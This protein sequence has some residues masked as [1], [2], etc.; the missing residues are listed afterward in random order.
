MHRRM[1]CAAGDRM[2][3]CT[4]HPAVWHGSKVMPI[5]F[6]LERQNLNSQAGAGART[7]MNS[8]G[9]YF[10]KALKNPVGL[11]AL[12]GLAMITIVSGNFIPVLVGLI[13]EGMFVTGAPMLPAWRRR[14]DAR[15]AALAVEVA[16]DKTRDELRA[17]PAAEQQRYQKLQATALAVRENYAQYSQASRD[18]LAQ[19]TARIDDMLARY[20]RMLIAKDAYAKH[21]ATNSASELENRVAKLD[22]EMEGDDER[23]R[24]V[25]AKQRAVLAQ[26]LEKL[27]KAE[28]DSSLLEAQLIT[29]EEMVMLL[30]EQ[31]ITMKEPEEMTAQL[32]TLI[33]EIE[34]T[35]STVSAIETSFELAFDRELK[36]AERGALPAP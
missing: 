20:L 14:I 1:Q 8:Y 12:G 34:N 10:L 3:R 5:F 16:E 21:L 27:Q 30:K 29:L 33:S 7:A 36:S 9:T 32:D 23:V 11:I 26:R 24:E 13:G 25:K 35:E 4:D 18:F 28:R 17:L 31:A 22:A 2:E 19:M 6:L 15:E